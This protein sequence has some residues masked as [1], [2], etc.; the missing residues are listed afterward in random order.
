MR[1]EK[2]KGGVQKKRR[3]EEKEKEKRGEK[4]RGPKTL[5]TFLHQGF[6]VRILFQVEP[7]NRRREN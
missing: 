6:T 2:I 3:K 7:W 5:R 4:N 1:T